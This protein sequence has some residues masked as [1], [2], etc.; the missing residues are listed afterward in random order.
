MID[1]DEIGE[2]VAA[3]ELATPEQAEAFRRYWDKH[4]SDYEPDVILRRDA[5]RVAA[6]AENSLKRVQ[7]RE[8]M[9]GFARSIGTEDPH[10]LVDA[11]LREAASKAIRGLKGGTPCESHATVQPLHGE[12]PPGLAYAANIPAVFA[13]VLRRSGVVGE[14]RLVRILYLALTSRLLDRPVSV[15]VKGPSSAGK[16][17]VVERVCSLFPDSAYHFLT[18][19]SEHSLVYS[20]EPL[21]HRMLVLSEAAGFTQETTDYFLRTLLS[22]GRLRYET[23]ESTK[24]GMEPRLIE[25][26]GPT[27]LILTTTAVSLHPE[28]ETRLLSITATD[29]PAQTRAVMMAAATGGPRDPVTLEC[30]RG[31]QTWLESAEHRVTIPYAVALAN[32]IPPVAIRLRRDFNT[33]LGLICSHALLHQLNRGRASDGSVLATTDDYAAVRELLV[34][35]IGDQVQAAV[36]PTTRET[37][38]T[39]ALLRERFGRPISYAELGNELRLDKST[40]QRRARLAL[41][42]GYLRND[43]DRRGKPAQLVLGD[44]LPKD[45][46]L[47]PMP[48]AL[49]GCTVAV[50]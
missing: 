50:V 36:S 27:G 18:G 10:A 20:R 46:E 48:S 37:V 47:L 8:Q 6:L 2:K 15:A 23:V 44:P 40:A 11:H 13:A 38:E 34:D 31:L 5:T 41:T 19:M 33:V 21:Q 14:E 25:R 24:N 12:E 43:E 30:W 1:W 45:L 26:E 35:L 4:A 16:S 22:E 29:T 3:Q 49:S 9:I 7:A 32:A 17:Y 28:N 39:V 42:R